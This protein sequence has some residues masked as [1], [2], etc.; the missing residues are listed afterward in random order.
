MSPRGRQVPDPACVPT[1]AFRALST[2]CSSSCLVDLFRS[3]TVCEVSSSRVS[4]DNQLL[5]LFAAA[6]PSCRWLRFACIARMRQL[7]APRLQGFDPTVSPL[8]AVELFALRAARSLL[9]FSLPRV[10]LRAPRSRPHEISALDL[11]RGPSP[12]CRRLIFSV[13]K[14]ARPSFCLQMFSP[15]EIVALPSTYRITKRF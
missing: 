9:E 8:S 2:V 11:R 15:F 10:L 12:W 1:S 13:S 5:R 14:N 4:P 7:A 3:T 6:L